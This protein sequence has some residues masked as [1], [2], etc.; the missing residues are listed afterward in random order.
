MK[1]LRFKNRGGIL[2]FGI[3]DKFKSS[4]MKYNS[5]NKNIIQ[6]KFNNGLFDSDLNIKITSSELINDLVLSL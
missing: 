3:G 5:V 6:S 4:K 2:Y 1:K